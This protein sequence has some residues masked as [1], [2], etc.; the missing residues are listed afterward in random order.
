VTEDKAVSCDSPHG[1]LLAA[2]ERPSGQSLRELWLVLCRHRRL[3]GAVVGGLLLACL[4]YCLVAPNQYEASAKVVLSASSASSLNLEAPQPFAAAS[5]LSEPVQQETLA[6]VLRSEQLAWNVITGLKLYQQPG[7][8]GHAQWL[9]GSFASRFP[10]FRTDAP[11]PAAQEYLLKRFQERLRVQSVPHTLL[12]QIS[13]RSRD[14][15]LSASVVNAVIRAY[16]QQENDVRVEATRQASERLVSQLKDLKAHVEQDGQRMAAFQRAHG[17]LTSPETLANGQ[18]SETQHT[19]ALLEVDELD[20][21]LVFSARRSTARRRRAIQ[22]WSSPPIRTSRPRAAALPPS[23]SSRFAPAAAHW[24]RSRP[25]SPSS[26][27]PTFPAWSRSAARC[28]TW[29]GRNRPRTPNWWRD[30]A[31]HGRRPPT[32]SNCCARIWIY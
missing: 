2:E 14:A 29:T 28:R 16:G 5:I 22:S 4:L 23:S 19:S 17:L 26:T 12:I 10:G 25:S 20:R 9:S 18:R 7:F 13:F 3:V 27:A 21:Q 31:A 6:S 8:M 30:S 32:A 15:A 24:K 1:P 11:A